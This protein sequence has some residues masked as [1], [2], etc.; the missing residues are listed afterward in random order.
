MSQRT[1]S[2][3]ERLPADFFARNRQRFMDR[4]ESGSVAVFF[5]NDKMPRSGDTFHPFRQNPDFYYLTGIDQE[6]CALILCPD[7]PVTSKREQLFLIETNDH[8][9][10]WE[11]AKVDK[12]EGRALSGIDTVHWLDA[13]DGALRHLL[14]Y[15]GAI[16]VNM[17]ENDR[18]G[19]AVRTRDWRFA[20]RMQRDF[21]LHDLKRSAPIMS[22]LRSIKHAEE[23]EVM[24]TACSITEA[25]FRHVLDIMKPGIEEFVVESNITHVF[26][27]RRARGHAYEPIIA[28]G[29]NACVLHYTSNN[30]VCADGE[31]VLMDFGCEYGN[32]A[33]DLTRTIPVNGRFSDRQR[34]VYDACLRVQRE[35]ISMLQ[36]GTTL[37]DFNRE[38]RAVMSSELIGLG[39]IDKGLDET[40]RQRATARYFPHGTSH[41][42]GLDVH[43][44]GDR[45]APIEEDMCFTVEPGIY[46]PDEDIGV[47]IENDVVVRA[48]GNLD[49][50]ASIPVEVEEIEGLM[51]G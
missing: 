35:A 43:D 33:S 1:T 20:E 49:L 40:D 10:V 7:M 31:L 16:Y 34:A 6:D 4:M 24:N 38:V 8:M 22:A 46:I 14:S 2:R 44:L 39:L 25:A 50:M 42:I 45:Y 21:P 19:S 11:G 3:Y 17:N 15:H 36:P 13:F 48:G 37:N 18:S 32:Y 5:S 26:H 29:G 9:A 51:N 28:S 12:D 27:S 41:F 47:R 23:V 30:D